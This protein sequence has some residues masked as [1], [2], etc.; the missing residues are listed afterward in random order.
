MLHAQATEKLA[1][2]PFAPRGARPQTS[3]TRSRSPLATGCGC[4]EV[5][6]NFDGHLP[7]R[8]RARARVAAGATANFLFHLT[9]HNIAKMAPR[10]AAAT[11]GTTADSNNE[12]QRGQCARPR[13]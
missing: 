1:R 12:R 6:N 9:S 5:V 8:P 3:T 7:V 4:N 2:C 13:A 10:G 11:T